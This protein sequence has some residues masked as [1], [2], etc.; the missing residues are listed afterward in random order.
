M[1][2]VFEPCLLYPFLWPSFSLVPCEVTT[3]CPTFLA[4]GIEPLFPQGAPCLILATEMVASQSHKAQSQMEIE[5]FQSEDVV[6]VQDWQGHQ[7]GLP[8]EGPGPLSDEDRQRTYRWGDG[9]NC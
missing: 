8:P 7:I 5:Q 4:I 3:F 6:R 2:L 1:E 9:L